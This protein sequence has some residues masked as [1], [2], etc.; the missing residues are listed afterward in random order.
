MGA[1]VAFAIV[2]ASSCLVGV[3][4][5]LANYPATMLPLEEPRVMELMLADVFMKPH[6]HAAPFIVGIC[7][8]YLIA[9][10]PFIRFRLVSG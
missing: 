9:T 6:T 2:V 3:Y 10:N 5:V 7:G 8:G 1:L 4:T